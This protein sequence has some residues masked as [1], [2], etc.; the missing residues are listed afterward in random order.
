[1]LTTST[2]GGADARRLSVSM[3]AP[4]LTIDRQIHNLTSINYRLIQQIDEKAGSIY[5]ESMKVM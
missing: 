5:H 1:M 3:N 4:L 2:S